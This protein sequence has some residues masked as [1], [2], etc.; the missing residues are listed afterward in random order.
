M[1]EADFEK[2]I[3]SGVSYELAKFIIENMDIEHGM[4]MI[5]A[6]LAENRVAEVENFLNE[7][8]KKNMKDAKAMF[9]K[10]KVMAHKDN[11]MGA[12]NFLM[13]SL[14]FDPSLKEFAKKDATLQKYAEKDWYKN[15]L[16]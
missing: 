2:I 1:S 3:E 11:E 6:L 14:K 16:S 12:K 15:M 4:K 7:I 9:L 10:S 5:D 8:L 13:M